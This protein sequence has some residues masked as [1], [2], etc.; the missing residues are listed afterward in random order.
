MIQTIVME[1][2]G[3]EEQW[4]DVV[5][6]EG[7]YQISN[8]GKLRN[9][10]G[11]ILKVHIAH[12]GY[13]Y[14]NISKNSV[15]KSKRVH[16]LVAEAFIPNPENKAEVNHKDGDKFN[17]HVENLEW[18]T[19][20][21]NNLHAFRTHLRPPTNEKPIGQYTLTGTLLNTYPNSHEAA[22]KTHVCQGHICRVCS[23][24]FQQL[25]G[26][27]WRYMDP[28]GNPI[29]PTINRKPLRPHSEKQRVMCCI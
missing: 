20:S 26:Y 28:N 6:Y 22:R 25:G 11:H 29:K 2:M 12:N 4:R 8:S 24:K 3:T 13:C 17:N 27:I 19:K 7:L 18:M 15:A 9:T 14:F 10:K 23:G 16:R 5:G 21:E 1:V